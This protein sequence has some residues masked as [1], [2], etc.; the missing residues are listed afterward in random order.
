[1]EKWLH[2]EHSG[3]T[4][5]VDILFAFSKLNTTLMGSMIGQIPFGSKVAMQSF[6]DTLETANRNM[7][8]THIEFVRKQHGIS[9]LKQGARPFCRDL[10]RIT[11]E[12][13]LSLDHVTSRCILEAPIQPFDTARQFL[14]SLD[15][16]SDAED[17]VT[18]W[19][20]DTVMGRAENV[21]EEVAAAA[22]EMGNFTPE[23]ED[24]LNTYIKE[25]AAWQ[26]FLRETV[27]HRSDHEEH[28]TLNR[29]QQGTA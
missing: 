6:V 20:I 2:S 11:A 25:S 1:M 9:P 4:E 3:G 22:I 14:E 24:Q 29:A 8:E 15:A 16:L 23:D 10:E 5:I 21:T 28:S 12:V 7:L 19:R 17:M 27:E 18:I 26:D 13:K